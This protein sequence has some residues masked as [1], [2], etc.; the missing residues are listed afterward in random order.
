M[1]E[2]GAALGVV[3][4]T[5]LVGLEA[6][7]VGLNGDSEGL[8]VGSGLHLGDVVDGDI[9]VV[10]D[11]DGGGGSRVIRAGS[12]GASVGVDGLELGVLARLVVLVGVGLETTIATVV[13]ELD[14][15]AIDKLLLGE[16]QESASG[17]LVS[18]LD[19]AGGGEGPA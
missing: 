7:L 18:A 5:R 12:L 16:A 3:E 19:G 2:G 6:I 11:G 15:S 9:S 1:V 13:A 10:R 4:D 17:N 8:E 14:V